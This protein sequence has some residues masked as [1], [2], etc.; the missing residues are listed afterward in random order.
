[1]DDAVLPRRSASVLVLLLLV[2]VAAIGVSLL[3]EQGSKAQATAGAAGAALATLVAAALIA[4]SIQRDG[5]WPSARG[6]AAGTPADRTHRPRVPRRSSSPPTRAAGPAP[7]DAL[8]LVLVIPL[9]IAMRDEL[10]VHFDA[11]DRREI[12]IDV[13]LIAASGAAILYLLHPA[14]RH[15][16]RDVRH[17]RRDRDPRG[18]AVRHVRGVVP[19]GADPAALPAV[20]RVRRLRARDRP[21][22]VGPDPRRGEHGRPA[23]ERDHGPLPAAAR[24]RPRHGAARPRARRGPGG[25]SRARSSR[26]RRSSP[27]AP[28]SPPWPC[29][30]TSA[31]S[32]RCSRP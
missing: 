3:T 15:R 4:G 16:R 8:L 30:T 25:A 9:T 21:V 18:G 11:D 24:G 7:A 17:R 22:R 12:A 5:A 20:P 32:G 6:I 19:V 23:G 31:A 14:R 13:W 27:R 29:W 28:R 10:R 1:M 26:A 2:G